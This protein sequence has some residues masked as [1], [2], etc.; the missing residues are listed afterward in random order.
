M[1]KMT[2]KMAAMVA[3]MMA[4]SSIG[5]VNAF[6]EEIRITD[7][8]QSAEVAL[9][10]NPTY[11]EN[12]GGVADPIAVWDIT[13]S[14]DNLVWNIQKTTNIETAT[15]TWDRDNHKYIMNEP[16]SSTTYELVNNDSAV[17]NIRIIND[18]NFDIEATGQLSSS[19]P[20][21]FTWTS[22][23]ELDASIAT[24]NDRIDH[25]TVDI[26]HLDNAWNAANSYGLNN[27][28]EATVGT[29]SYTFNIYGSVY[30]NTGSYA[31]TNN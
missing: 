28:S 1:M 18:S 16:S 17:K 9:K 10:V 21:C 22:G 5:A 15:L 24:G 23:S 20:S 3:A 8:S 13:V 25:V 11:V 7:S 30:T 14:A 27:D 6:A 29:L 31:A 12:S 4:V 26:A 19:T 2:R